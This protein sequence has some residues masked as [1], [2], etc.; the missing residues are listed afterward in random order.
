MNEQ[1][2]EKVE[3]QVQTMMAEREAYEA[4]LRRE[5]E[6]AETAARMKSAILNNMSHELRTPMA[7][8]LGYAQILVHEADNQQNEFAQYILESGERLMNTLND[9]LEL[10]ELE[11]KAA[12]PEAEEADLCRAAHRAADE[13]ET[14]A[15]EK[16]LTMDRAIPNEPLT[17]TLDGLA[18]E[19]IIDILV[20][21]AVKYT[22]EGHVRVTVQR[23]EAG[24][25]LRVEDTGIGISDAFQPELFEPFHQERMDESREYQG[26]GLGLS[27]AKR[28]VDTAGG[29]IEVES[30]K[31]EGTQF[32][33]RFPTT[34][35]R[36]DVESIPA[37]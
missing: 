37:S 7:S 19:R 13:H 20:E 11:A 34:A 33:V 28:L 29:T 12:A 32:T 18:L 2:E 25:L 4:Q 17:V 5:K 35:D 31:G 26:E 8:I 30:T 1:L 16:G 23:A 22:E 3:E 21:N 9:V 10:S 15:I 24:A 14:T 6:R 27:I 36:N